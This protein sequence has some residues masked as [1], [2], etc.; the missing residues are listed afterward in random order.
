MIKRAV[1]LFVAASLLGP[2]VASA[3]N[4]AAKAGKRTAKAAVIRRAYLAEKRKVKSLQRQLAAAR[5]TNAKLQSQLSS[6]LR[7]AEEQVRREVGWSERYAPSS[8]SRGALTAL[9]AMNYV[10]T[11]VSST[12]YA[13]F[14][15]PGLPLPPWSL[16]LDS[17]ANTILRAQAG[18]CGYH[19]LVF[20]AIMQHLG[21]MVRAVNFDYQDPWTGKQGAHSAAEVYYDSAWHFFD[22][23]YDLYWTNPTSGSVLSIADERANGGA[24]HR[25]DILALN[26]F[27]D[28]FYGGNDV[29]FETAPATQIFYTGN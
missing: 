12:T 28:P 25:D 4:A 27:E 18:E 24:Q 15:P 20:T 29:A 22:P 21:Y 8:Y 19:V 9:A 5:R 2:A 23:T 16:D 3:H 7:N 13:Y 26:L 1:V 14:N 11:H 10:A 6:T 17:N